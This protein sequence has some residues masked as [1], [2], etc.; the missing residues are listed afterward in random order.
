MAL[1]HVIL[2]EKIYFH[3]AHKHVFGQN[4]N[5]NDKEFDDT[6]FND[7]GTWSFVILEGD[8]EFFRDW[9]FENK[10]G[11]TL[12]PG[13]YDHVSTA[14]GVANDMP[15]SSLRSVN[16]LGVDKRGTLSDKVILD[17]RR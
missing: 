9:N 5:L 6:D 16:V 11:E 1:P 7:D 10:L 13:F 14:L 15:I 3:G 4:V 12:G 17:G 8:W 2:F